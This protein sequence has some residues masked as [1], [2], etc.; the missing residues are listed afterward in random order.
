MA[1]ESNQSGVKLSDI[2]FDAN[3][4]EDKTSDTIKEVDDILAHT[5]GQG[6]KGLCKII[7]SSLKLLVKYDTA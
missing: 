2:E 3:K 4:N 7:H 5:K 6:S 1:G